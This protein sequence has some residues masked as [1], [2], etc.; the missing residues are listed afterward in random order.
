[1]ATNSFN[2]E[3][4]PYMKSCF[5]D[6]SLRLLISS[7]VND[8]RYKS[9][10]ISAEQHVI[11]I[12]HDFLIQELSNIKQEFTDKGALTY[13]RIVKNKKRDRATSLMYGLSYI[14][15]LEQE[16]RAKLY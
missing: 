3:F 14:Y 13:T 12:E 7:S 1:M 16:G 5:E 11:N 2:I 10:E 8:E 4:Y 15:E 6:K 9:G